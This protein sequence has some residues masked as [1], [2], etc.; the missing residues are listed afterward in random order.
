MYLFS[1]HNG[2]KPEIINQKTAGKPQ[3]TG[4][5]NNILLSSTWVKEKNLN[6]NFKIFWAKWIWNTTYQNLQDALKRS[7]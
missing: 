1:D 7:A 5:V 6:G 2:V 4:R 3:N